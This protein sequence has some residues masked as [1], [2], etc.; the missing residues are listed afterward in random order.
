MRTNASTAVVLVLQLVSG[1]N[2]FVL[3]LLE[4]HSLDLYAMKDESEQSS[5]SK[6]LRFSRHMNR[7]ADIG[8]Y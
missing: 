7:F 4:F 3:F 2:E 6:I 5:K 8:M 1:T